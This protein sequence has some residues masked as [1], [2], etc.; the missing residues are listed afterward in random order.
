MSGLNLKINN[1]ELFDLFSEF[2]PLVKCNINY[3]SLGRS[4]G[5]A[6]IRYENLNDG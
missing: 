1:Q 6:I 2:G 4:K 5:N 3:D